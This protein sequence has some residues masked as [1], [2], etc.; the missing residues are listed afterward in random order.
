MSP[1]TLRL[2]PLDSQAMEDPAND[3]NASSDHEA[4]I[5]AALLHAIVQLAPELIKVKTPTSAS[6]EIG[7]WKLSIAIEP[8]TI[9][10]VSGKDSDPRPQAVNTVR[11]NILQ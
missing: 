6:I 8:R 1:E 11:S 9:G 2:A 3:S 5:D 4:R 7:P 10:I